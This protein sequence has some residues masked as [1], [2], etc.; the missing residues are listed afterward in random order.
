V[1]L[2]VKADNVCGESEFSE[3]LIIYLNCTT[4]VGSASENHDINISPNPS[5][6]QFFVEFNEAKRIVKISIL[7][8]YSKLLNK[9]ELF[10]NKE[11]IPIDHSDLPGGLYYVIIETENSK[12]FEKVVFID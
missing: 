3:A 10:D 2:T 5:K 6:D 9:I 1:E 7:N 11:I 8:S 12:Y 4:E